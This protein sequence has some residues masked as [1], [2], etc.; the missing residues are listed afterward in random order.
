MAA[1]ARQFVSQK[2]KR[3]VNAEEN[4]DLDLSYITDRIIAMGFPSEGA[5]GLYRNP[6][7]MVLKFMKLQHG[8]DNVK[9][10]PFC[11]DLDRWLGGH[12]KRV[13]A[14]HCKA[15]KGRTG[16]VC[17]AYLA[18]LAL[19]PSAGVDAPDGVVGATTA[20]AHFAASRTEDGKGVTIPSQIRWV[21]YWE[22]YLRT[23]AYRHDPD[24]GR[25]APRRRLRPFFVVKCMRAGGAWQTVKVHDQIKSGAKIRKLHPN[26]RFATLHPD[27]AV[28]V[29]GNVNVGI[30]DY[31][32]GGKNE[33]ICSVWFNT[34]FVDSNYLLFDKP[35]LDGAVKDRKDRVSSRHFKLEIY[36]QE[37]DAA[38][39]D[40]RDGEAQAVVPAGGGDEDDDDDDDEA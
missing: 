18:R 15:G 2:K 22:R 3:W 29:R 16:L 37:V 33:K 13:A 30:Y 34:A 5:A 8:L 21:H 25:R 26:E 40:D 12:P 32:W 36:L 11:D 4:I 39:Y 7:P 35:V 14:I 38:L 24:D 23:G 6:M 9:L 27:A 19:R 28:V 17:A 31:D 1:W 10:A 20:L